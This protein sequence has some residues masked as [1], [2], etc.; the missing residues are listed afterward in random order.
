[1]KKAEYCKKHEPIAYTGFSMFSGLDINGIEGE[2]VYFT[3]IMGSNTTY[4]KSKIYYT[5]N[6]AF[7][8]YNGRRIHLNEC[9]RVNF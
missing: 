2:T 5:E 8:L 3:A 6:S 4:H 9:I 7:F 1:M